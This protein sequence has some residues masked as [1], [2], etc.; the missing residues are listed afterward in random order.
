VL[1]PWAWRNLDHHGRFVLVASD[2]G[3]TF[4]T[5]NHPWQPGDGDMAANPWLKLDSQALR[6]RHPGLTEEQME[7]IY[8]REAFAWIRANPMDWLALEARKLF[9]TVVPIGSSYKLHSPLY[10]WA[11]VLS[12]GLLLP[13]SIL[14]FI[15]LGVWRRRT[16]GLWIMALAAVGVCLVFF[17]QERFRIPTIDPTLVICAGAAF[18][19]RAEA[20]S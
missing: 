12:Y 4:W 11:S 8:Y 3:V 1:L 10:F 16:P 6:A 15:R 13:F 18:L 5:G 2:G 9:Y 7:P 19:R 14:G 17:P 20:A